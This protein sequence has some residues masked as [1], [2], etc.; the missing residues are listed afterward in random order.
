VVLPLRTLVL[1]LG[2]ASRMRPLSLSCPK[3]LIPF[4]GRP[5]LD[6]T[7][8][9]L[10]RHGFVD[11]T[12]VAGSCD[13]GFDEYRSRCEAA[14]RSVAVVKRGL[15]F[16]SAGVVRDVVK[17]SDAGDLL[18]VYGDSILRID[19]RAMLRFHDERRARG[20]Q[21]TVAYHSPDDL[22]VPGHAHTNYGLLYF[23]RD[24]RV[25]R[26]VEK[27]P[28]DKLVSAHASAGVF[29]FNR[30]VLDM[31]WPTGPLDFSRDILAT[32]ASGSESPVFGFDIADGYRFDI[33]TVQEF[34]RRQFAVLEGRLELAGMPLERLHSSAR[35]SLG[36]T[37]A[38]KALV[39]EAC[40]LAKTAR[41]LGCNVLGDG[42]SV[43][44]GAEIEN[45]IVLDGTSIGKGARVRAAVLGRS[46][47]I[48]EG[49]CL[50]DG[51]VVGDYCVVG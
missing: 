18:V 19:F 1:C 41:L 51:T 24:G 30:G 26:F 46:C 49:A 13:A 32:L 28:V 38:G 11:V 3:A 27:P 22:V 42:V 40:R 44:D 21:V 34:V 39:G 29:L 43:E 14:G 6:Y 47:V 37:V 48:L 8:E 45:S 20:C 36:C 9:E 16:G 10:A 25:T 50:R 31:P 7:L 4:C 35:S 33:G 12:I 5:L 17:G 15:E 23:D 2:S